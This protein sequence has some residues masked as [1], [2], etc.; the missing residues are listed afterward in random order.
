MPGPVVHSIIAEKLPDAFEGEVS[1]VPSVTNRRRRALV[2]GSQG[3]DPFFFNLD[4]LTGHSVAKYLIEWQNL[5]AKISH[6]FWKF[7]EPLAEVGNKIKA[8]GNQAILS[9]SQHSD[10]IDQIKNLIIQFS[11]GMFLAS[12]VT[13]G[14][15]KKTVLDNADPF[16]LYVSPLQTCGRTKDLLEGAK[17]PLDGIGGWQE[18]A[19]LDDWWWFDLLHSRRTGDFA[20]H[21]LDIAT[22]KRPGNDDAAT[23]RDQLL[24][25]AIGYLSHIAADV[26]GHAYVN[27]IVGGPYRIGQ[28][29]RH[30]AQEKIM[31]VWAYNHYYNETGFLQGLDDRDDRYYMNEDVVDSGMHKNFLFTAGRYEPRQWERNPEN[32]LNHSPD[33]PIKSGIKLPEEISKNF[34]T[35]TERAYPEERFGSLTADEVDL[36]YRGWYS[37]FRNATTT[38]SPFKPN[39]IPG[40]VKITEKLKEEL[41]EAREELDDVADAT[42]NVADVFDHDGGGDIGDCFSGGNLREVTQSAADCLSD[43][44]ESVANFVA[45]LGEAIA[46]L[47]KE[48]GQLLWSVFEIADAALAVPLRAIN[49]K[50]RQAYE[51]LWASYTHLLKLIT[52][53]GFSYM[54]WDDLDETRQLEHLY[55]PTET[56]AIG[57]SSPRNTIVKPGSDSPGFPRYGLKLGHGF[58]PAY[59]GVLQ[60]LENEGHLIVPPTEI[61]QEPTIPGPDEYG[62]HTP[63]V[64]IDDP[65]G[66]LENPFDDSRESPMWSWIAHP[67]RNSRNPESTTASTPNVEHFR[68]GGAEDG[69]ED[70]RNPVLGDAVSLT[71]E[72]YKYYR[73]HGE[74]PNL[75]MSGDRA[76]G[77]PTWANARGCS[78][79]PRERWKVLHGPEVPWL[80]DPIDPVFVPEVP[81]TEWEDSSEVPPD[82]YY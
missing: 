62:L 57:I 1:T 9:A 28:A 58:D 74:L 16:G 78:P 10:I 8:A 2:Y 27:S 20:T 14:F 34:V 7:R 36:S 43:A 32:P 25:Y 4:D 67:A 70:Y 19:N 64:F 29:Q 38:R 56:D 42:E 53:I 12:K 15:V 17:S 35:A 51:K 68:I 18:V 75:N 6:A 22:G 33:K 65:N 60:G 26:V 5:K 40:D 24:S 79:E 73:E 77:F 41:Q 48:I 21:L 45:N 23:Q 82:V 3:P 39:E 76:I 63:E 80:D 71:V 30:T 61:E 52:A 46:N 37:F 44:A 59:T 54:Y 31:D 47:F 69:R 13:S 49:Y 11:E 72:L 81:L 50:L 55:D 66:V